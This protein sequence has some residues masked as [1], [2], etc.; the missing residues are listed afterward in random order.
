MTTEIAILMI[1]EKPSAL[2]YTVPAYRDVH[3]V[4]GP[5]YGITN[6]SMYRGF[7]FAYPRGLAINDYPLIRDPVWRIDHSMPLDCYRYDDGRNERLIQTCDAFDLAKRARHIVLAADSSSS[8]YAS[9]DTFLTMTFGP[10]WLGRVHEAPHITTYDD[11]MLRREIAGAHRLP[12]HPTYGP[13]DAEALATFQKWVERGRRQRLIEYIYTTNA[14]ALYGQV[15]R[16]LGI[17]ADDWVISRWGVQL[18]YGMR[19]LPPLSEAKLMYAMQTWRNRA[20]QRQPG[21]IGS[22]ASRHGIINDLIRAGLIGPLSPKSS[23]NPNWAKDLVLTDLGRAFLVRLHPDTEDRD[24]R[25]RVNAWIEEGL[26][27]RS[28]IERYY[29]TVFG[30]QKR[31]FKRH[32]G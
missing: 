11:E 6:G 3:G 21:G 32:F 17:P 31:F 2:N 15:L 1:V 14:I 20:G 22:P 28:K 5:I 27:S 26:S 18:L 30:K 23:Q 29:R 7:K 8:G 12:G 25:D 16:S 13:E 9:Q 19:N 10:D 24:L 4:T